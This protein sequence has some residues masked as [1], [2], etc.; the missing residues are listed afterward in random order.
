M[1][2]VLNAEIKMSHELVPKPEYRYDQY[3]RAEER[4]R[5][6]KQ[7]RRE[8]PDLALEDVQEM[9]A[10]RRKATDREVQRLDETLKHA[11]EYAVDNLP[12]LKE[13]AAQEARSTGKIVNPI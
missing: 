3:I 9:A 1:L 8:L 4:L 5:T 11:K 13:Q 7:A 6:M 12:G 10:Q 2:F